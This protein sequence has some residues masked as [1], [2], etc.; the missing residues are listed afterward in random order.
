MPITFDFDFRPTYSTNDDYLSD[1][2]AGALRARTLQEDE[3]YLD[4]SLSGLSEEIDNFLDEREY[5]FLHASMYPDF[6]EEDDE[7]SEDNYDVDEEA[8]SSSS[9]S[10]IMARASSHSCSPKSF[11]EP[12]VE[13]EVPA[14]PRS[15]AHVSVSL[16]PPGRRSKRL[17][18]KGPVDYTG[19][20][21]ED[22]D[23]E[24]RPAKRHKPL[25]EVQEE[26]ESRGNRARGQSSQKG[27]RPAALSA[28]KKAR[29]RSLYKW[30]CELCDMS[31]SDDVKTRERHVASKGHKKA[32]KLKDP[33]SANVMHNLKCPFCHKV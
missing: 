30:T 23:E 11:S 14:A 24:E 31:M 5:Y 8:A 2:Y 12:Q 15:G 6:D 3:H 19:E 21:D 26:R 17:L 7:G 13:H 32:L 29:K 18:L 16:S 9:A 33:G 25:A 27:E 22:E 20:E 10:P 4:P 28:E 1:M